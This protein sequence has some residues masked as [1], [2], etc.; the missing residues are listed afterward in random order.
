MAKVPVGVGAAIIA[1]I[2]SANEG[3]H[4]A[5]NNVVGATVI[6]GAAAK[7]VTDNLNNHKAQ[8]HP[9]ITQGGNMGNFGGGH[10]GAAGGE[11]Y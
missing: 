11:L 6:A 8:T 3:S 5:A 10:G 4:S 7:M 9:S 1:G 2:T